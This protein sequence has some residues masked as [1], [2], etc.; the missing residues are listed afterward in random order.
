MQFEFSNNL[1]P[2]MQAYFSQAAVTVH[3]CRACACC[4]I[5]SVTVEVSD[6]EIYILN[7]NLFLAFEMEFF[8][9]WISC[10]VTALCKRNNWFHAQEF[11]N[12]IQN[13]SLGRLLG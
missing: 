10:D 12:H 1:R 7:S 2:V 3:L 8:G 4:M 13:F 6:L 11:S 5:V 9:S